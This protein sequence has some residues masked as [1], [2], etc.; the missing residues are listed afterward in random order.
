MPVFDCS[1]DYFVA[2]VECLQMHPE[3]QRTVAYNA[4][5]CFAKLIPTYGMIDNTEPHRLF[6]D[7]IRPSNMLVDP[8]TMEVTAF[9]DF[10]FVNIMPAQFTYDLPWLLI[11]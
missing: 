3:T 8:K 11:L 6:C 2:R 9:L 4:R 1:S 7:N 10:E 5:H